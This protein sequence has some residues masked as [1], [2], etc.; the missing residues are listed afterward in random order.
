MAAKLQT[1]IIIGV[2]DVA[3]VLIVVASYIADVFQYMNRFYLSIFKIT[4]QFHEGNLLARVPAFYLE[5]NDYFCDI[6]SN[7]EFKEICDRYQMFYN[8]SI[9]YLSLTLINLIIVLYNLIHLASLGLE[10]KPRC[11]LSM[12][13]SHYLYPITH[14]IAILAYLW[15]V[16]YYSLT[17]PTGFGSDFEVSARAGLF[18]ML[19][20]QVVSTIGML[21]YLFSRNEATGNESFV[22][23]TNEDGY[24]KIEEKPD[25]KKLPVLKVSQVFSS[26]S[27]DPQP[28][29]SKK[30]IKSGRNSKEIKERKSKTSEKS[31][32]SSKEKSGQRKS[33]EDS[34]DFSQSES[35]SS[36]SSI[37]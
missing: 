5:F 33:S 27:E 6:R 25:M 1:Y 19:F 8:G 32:K 10:W 31:K 29:N 13:C 9:V 23:E 14:S 20:A 2:L 16:K 7:M 34:E 18:L 3:Y 28:K 24:Q 4:Y 30:T 26:D 22:E 11:F 35:G 15:T 21:I 36:D 37:D 12:G 17:P